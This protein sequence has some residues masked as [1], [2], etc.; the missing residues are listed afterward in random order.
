MT[1]T[2]Y[3]D[4]CFAI[5]N[6]DKIKPDSI[7][8]VMVDLPYGQINHEWDSKI[9]LSLMW[10]SLSRV[11]KSNCQ[12][13]FFCNTRFGYELIKSKEA[14][15]R[16]DLVYKK[17]NSVGWLCAKKKPMTNHEMIYVFNTSST[18]D[19]NNNQ[20]G[21]EYFRKVLKFINAPTKN[22]IHEKLGHY[23]AT[24]CLTPDGLQ[25]TAPTEKTY[26]DLIEH[27]N[28]DKLDGF[29][30]YS[31]LSDNDLTTVRPT[32][33][34][35]KKSGFKN[36]DVPSN[37]KA[38]V[39]YGKPKSWTVVSDGTR[40]QNSCELYTAD[41]LKFHPTQKPQ[42]LCEYLVK[43]YSN[44]GDLVLDFTMGSGSTIVACKTTGR[45]YIG[46]EKNKDYFDVACQ[47]LL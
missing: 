32:F 41:K 15:F 46:I 16:Y 10:A 6:G 34:V 38:D 27:F 21:R 17:P 25:F 28:I 22:A 39:L 24:H 43:T 20:V 4:D 7:D 37:E 5:F 11:C 30:A 18:N 42:T 19:A 45:N 33:N 31:D 2:L 14:W 44:E 9:D 8:L 29:I 12:Y 35:V 13:L 47:R 3:N 40:Y 1:N 26:N 36:Y 23:A